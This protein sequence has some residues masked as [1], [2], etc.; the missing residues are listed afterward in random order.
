MTLYVIDASVAARFLLSEELSDKAGLVLKDF[1]NGKI[2]LAFPELTIYEVGNAVWKAVRSG[3]VP[4]DEAEE[5]I[6]RLVKL[7]IEVVR[8]EGED[9][10]EILRW[11]SDNDVTYYD[12]AYVV[13]SK[14]TDGALLTADDL[15]YEK[16]KD[17]IKVVHLRDYGAP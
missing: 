4:L 17:T 5:K 8:F 14:K 12:G 6:A 7:G 10:R 16:A 11:S 13:A 15:L 2:S 1:L 9:Y 3:F